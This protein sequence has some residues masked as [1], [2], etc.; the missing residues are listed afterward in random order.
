MRN[1]SFHYVHD[2]PLFSDDFGI[3][4]TPL[5]CG[6]TQLPSMSAV[7]VFAGFDLSRPPPPPRATTT[8]VIVV[9]VFVVFF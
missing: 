1:M 6:S 8:G 3:F 7:A 4:P 2:F 9:I 5:S